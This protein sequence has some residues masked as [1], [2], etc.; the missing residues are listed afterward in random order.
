LRLASLGQLS[1]GVL[2]TIRLSLSMPKQNELH[3][4]MLWFIR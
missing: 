1:C 3:A 2:L 4:K